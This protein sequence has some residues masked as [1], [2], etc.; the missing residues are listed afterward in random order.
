MAINKS[1]DAS[2]SYASEI[3]VA[4]AQF[5]QQ[6]EPVFTKLV[7]N[8]PLPKGAKNVSVPKYAA[9]SASAL[10]EGVDLASPTSLT[11]THTT[12]T[13]SEAGLLVVVTRDVVQ[14]MND[15]VMQ[16]VGRLLGE[17]LADY[18]DEAGV[19]LFS[20]LNTTMGTSGTTITVGHISAGLAKLMNVPARPPFNCVLHPYQTHRIRS[21]VAPAATYP[22]PVGP[23]AEQLRRYMVGSIFSVPIYE[24]GRIDVD[25]SDDAYGAIFNKQTFAYTE[26]FGI[27]TDTT[28]DASLRAWELVATTK[29]AVTEINGTWGAYMLFDSIAPT[30]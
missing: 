6:I 28:W 17:A 10:S 18:V 9:L 8:I 14:Q 15:A 21:A 12:I 3:I 30:A 5:A 7:T 29:F 25:G 24:D 22:I 4:E 1:S 2:I 16:S 26:E 20:A 13:P 23:A 11:V 27:K 19:D